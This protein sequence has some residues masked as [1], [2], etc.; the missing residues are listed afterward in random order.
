MAQDQFSPDMLQMLV[1]AE[2]KRNPPAVSEPAPPKP[3][4]SPLSWGMLLGGR[5]ADMATT[6]TALK[7]GGVEKNSLFGNSVGKNLALQGLIG[8]GEA[9]GLHFLAK[10]HPKE[11]NLIAKILGGAEMGAATWNLGQLHK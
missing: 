2:L 1:D 11:A 7:R 6:A 5:G 8:G 3:G 4:L 9:V 10:K